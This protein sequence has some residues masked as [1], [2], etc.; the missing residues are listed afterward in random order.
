MRRR[1]RRATVDARKLREKSKADEA[2]T[3]FQGAVLLFVRTYPEV[4]ANPL[5]MARARRIIRQEVE[6][7]VYGIIRSA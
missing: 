1:R 7:K 3:L 4:A 2:G 5:A 6:A